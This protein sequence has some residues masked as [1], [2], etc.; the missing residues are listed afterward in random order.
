MPDGIANYITKFPRD[1]WMVGCGFEDA[2]L[3]TNESN[4][5][6]GK[7]LTDFPWIKEG[8]KIEMSS[9]FTVG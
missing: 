1:E 9:D 6:Y 4:F 3:I 8:V 5:F 2:S 7:K